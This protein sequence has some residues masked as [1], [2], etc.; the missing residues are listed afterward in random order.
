MRAPEHIRTSVA[1]RYL[2]LLRRAAAARF[3]E[4]AIVEVVGADWEPPAGD[5]QAPVPGS[6]A[7]ANG[8]G[9]GPHTRPPEPQVHLR[10]VRDRCGQPLRSRGGAVRGG[11]ARPL[12]QPALPARLARNRQDAPPARDRHLRRALRIRSEGALRDHRGVH[13]RV[14]GGRARKEHGRL[15]AALSQRGRGPHRRRPVPRRPRTHARG[16]LPHVQRAGGRRPAAGDDLG[17]RSGGHPGPGGS[18][19]RAIPLRPR[20]GARHPRGGGAAR[21]PRQASPPRRPRGGRC[22]DRRDRGPRDH[23][24][25]GAR[26]RP[27]PRRR[28]CLAE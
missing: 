6:T 2:P 27:D 17:L 24:R 22:G 14:R 7:L 25:A 28:L 13:E 16:V 18:P 19:D 15:Q 9:A 20:G 10:S 4:H 5:G 11:A 3:D 8:H 12:V 1:E 21:H 26:G 23:Q